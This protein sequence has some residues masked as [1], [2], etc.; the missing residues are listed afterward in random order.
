MFGQG[1]VFPTEH[2]CH[3]KVP[4]SEQEVAI[5][6]E[7]IRENIAGVIEESKISYPVICWLTMALV[8]LSIELGTV[9]RPIVQ[10][11]S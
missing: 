6:P 7:H 8:I 1:F 2:F 11:S 9:Y 10:N 4:E 5:E 3:L